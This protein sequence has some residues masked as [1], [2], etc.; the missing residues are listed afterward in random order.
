[1]RR[2]QDSDHDV[3]FI[4]IHPPEWYLSINLQGTEFRIKKY[5]CVLRPILACLWIEKYNR[6][7]PICFQELMEEILPD[8][9][10]KQ[11]VD[12]LFERKLAGDELDLEP[13]IPVTN[14]LAFFK[15]AKIRTYTSP[16]K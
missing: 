8:G 6:T 9:E 3:R 15:S 7:P 13:R 1:M 4:Y 16:E 5:V 11:T 2:L 10:L 14:H 12:H